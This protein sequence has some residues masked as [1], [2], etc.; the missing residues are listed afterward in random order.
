MTLT[1]DYN[2]PSRYSN[3]SSGRVVDHQHVK[4]LL[5]ESQKLKE[6]IKGN[7]DTVSNDPSSDPMRLKK[8]SV[9]H[10]RHK[11]KESLRSDYFRLDRKLHLRVADT[12]AVE[13]QMNDYS[14]SV[15]PN[16][17]S[18]LRPV[19]YNIPERAESDSERLERRI[20]AINLRIALC[21]REESGLCRRSMP[22]ISSLG[23]DKFIKAVPELPELPDLQDFLQPPEPLYSFEQSQQDDTNVF[24]LV[25]RPMQCPIYIGDERK[26][27]QD[28]T[29]EFSKR[30]KSWNHAD[31]AHLEAH[32]A[33]APIPCHH[34]II[35][36]QN[37][38]LKTL[39]SFKT[40][41]EQVHQIKL[42]ASLTKG[43]CAER[44]ATKED[45]YQID[46]LCT[47]N[48]GP[49]YARFCYDTM[50]EMVVRTILCGYRLLSE[51]ML[52]PSLQRGQL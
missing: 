39:T 36:A 52:S 46:R 38:V 50:F 42:K 25:C 49:R 45:C 30:D 8:G 43:G 33:Y 27:Y 10:A 19:K 51:C 23:L 26:S 1:A 22:T 14:N 32:L 41:T 47:G 28:R 35:L 24:P 5:K 29:F 37:V 11:L 20:T 4:R 15:L 9:D 13:A 48:S 34:L 6:K 18:P 16:D 7:Y 17:D 31:G 21:R 2:A 12:I 40:Q 44:M 3:K